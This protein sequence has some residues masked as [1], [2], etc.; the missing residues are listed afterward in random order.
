MTKKVSFND[1][2]VITTYAL[3]KDE[4][5]EKRTHNK[6][7]RSVLKMRRTLRRKKMTR[8][9]FIKRGLLKLKRREIIK[10]A[11]GLIFKDI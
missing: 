2:K 1:I 4:R 3:L 8:D 9:D 5:D 6:K 7:L 10:K 11:N